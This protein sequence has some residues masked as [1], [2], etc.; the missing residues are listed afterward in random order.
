MRAIRIPAYLI[1]ALPVLFS[2][3]VVLWAVFHVLPLYM[4]KAM[5]AAI[6]AIESG[7]ADLLVSSLLLAGAWLLGRLLFFETAVV[8]YSHFW[9]RKILLMRRNLLEWLM[10]APKARVLPKGSS[11]A[12]TTFREDVDQVANYMEDIVDV[13][14]LVIFVWLAGGSLYAASP[15]LT[16][17]ALLPVAVALAVTLIAR[18][19]I[20]RLRERMRT[21]TETVTTFIGDTF[22]A[23][24]TIKATHREA[25]ILSHLKQINLLRNQAALRDTLLSELLRSFTRNMSHVATGVVLL[26]G[27]ND[28]RN[29]TLTVAELSLFLIFLPRVTGYMSWFVEMLAQYQGTHV[30]FGRMLDLSGDATAADLLNGRSLGFGDKSKP[31]EPE[32]A[33]STGGLDQLDVR[34]LTYTYA[35]DAG[36]ISN[37]SFSLP[38]GSFTVITGRV[39]AGKSTLV[40]ALLGLVPT[41]EG[42][43]LWNGQEIEDR[44]TFLIPPRSAYTPQVPQLVSESLRRNIT[45]GRP[46][47]D[48]QVNKAL[49]MAV[50]SHDVDRMEQGLKTKVGSRGIRLSGGQVQRSAAARMFATDADLLV[51]DDLSSALDIHTESALWERLF[52]QRAD[53]TC[54]VVSHRR[55]ALI[56]ADQIVLMSEGKVAGVGTL[57]ELLNDHQEMRALWD[58]TT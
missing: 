27:A 43:V 28:L 42:E 51:F 53:V 9:H 55:P 22:G 15:R 40:R 49:S 35:D 21:A 47:T 50:M 5:A 12:V 30:S 3:N 37:V 44:T 16:F 32:S 31:A 19:Y 48:E 38:R 2:V 46:M 23:V 1:R 13:S 36:G 10:T 41:Q 20:R 18:P 34:S 14:G 26:L 58:E 7:D 52:Q 24:E 6:G 56:R 17:W 25:G 45:M 4:G 57:D 39:G 11:A 29:G 33:T 54:L 8:A